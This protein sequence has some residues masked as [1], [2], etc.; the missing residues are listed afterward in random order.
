MV[1]K[2]F[3]ERFLVFFAVSFFLLGFVSG[4]FQSPAPTQPAPTGA[5]PEIASISPE[6]GCAGRTVTITGKNFGEVQGESRVTFAPCG[7]Q[8]R[9]EAEVL[10]WSD[11]VIAVKVPCGACSGEVVVT[12]NGL[13]SN[14]V[15]FTV[16]VC[17]PLPEPVSGPVYNITQKKY[18]TTIQEAIDEDEEGDEIVVSPRIYRENIDFKGK[19]ITLR[20]TDPDHPECTVIEGSGGGPVVTFVGESRS[21]LREELPSATLQGFTIR[22]ASGDNG[23]GVYVEGASL[24]I[25]Q[26]IITGNEDGGIYVSN[27]GTESN[28]VQISNNTI[29]GNTGSGIAV[30][31]GATGTCCGNTIEGNTP[32]YVSGVTCADTCD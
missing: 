2:I 26:N 8:T 5:P 17:L 10:S 9:V 14:G 29:T 16:C 11:T 25:E 18:Y 20:S 21:R 31:R 22:K 28:P 15:A 7:A 23:V 19:N 4:C 27:S 30:T 32:N 3:S 13:D 12:V 24:S 1:E 6:R